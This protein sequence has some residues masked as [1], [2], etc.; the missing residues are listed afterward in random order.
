MA[1]NILCECP[2]VIKKGDILKLHISSGVLNSPELSKE[3]MGI[4]LFFFF[5]YD[6]Q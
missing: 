4:W 3:V 5:L 6:A 1:K 2:S